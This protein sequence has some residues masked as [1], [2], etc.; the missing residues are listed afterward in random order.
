MYKT[1]NVLALGLQILEYLHIACMMKS[2]S[3]FS[4]DFSLRLQ[5]HGNLMDAQTMLLSI[6]KYLKAD[7]L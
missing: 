3:E 6:T 5:S 2:F 7:N 4:V 1:S